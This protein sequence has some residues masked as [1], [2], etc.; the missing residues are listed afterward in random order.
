VAS[1]AV[2]VRAVPKE[3][4]GVWRRTPVNSVPATPT[5]A[6]AD[7]TSPPPRAES[8]APAKFRPGALG[9]G[10]WRQRE[11]E[12]AG[13]GAAPSNGAAAAGPA[14]A[15]PSRVSGTASPRPSSPAPLREEPRKDD[16]GFQTVAGGR[17]VWR[18]RRGRA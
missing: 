8:P 17:G 10:G 18:P 14:A 9:G 12:K 13:G 1:S 15:V 2:P 6:A 16:D 5:R 7:T 3:E 4:T 11:Q